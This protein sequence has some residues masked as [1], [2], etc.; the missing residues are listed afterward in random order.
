ML[1]YVSLLYKTF[2]PFIVMEIVHNVYAI[3]LAI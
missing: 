2:L 1:T 3:D